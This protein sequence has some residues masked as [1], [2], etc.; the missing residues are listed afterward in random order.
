MTIVQLVAPSLR[1]LRSS[2]FASA[3]QPGKKVVNGH[4]DSGWE[5]AILQVLRAYKDAGIP[6]TRG[7]YFGISAFGRSFFLS[8]G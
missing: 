2:F 5:V 7:T 1:Q 6:S 4:D 8:F 3:G